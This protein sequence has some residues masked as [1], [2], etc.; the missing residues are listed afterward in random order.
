MTSMARVRCDPFRPTITARSRA[1]AAQT[2]GHEQENSIHTIRSALFALAAAAYILAITIGAAA[3]SSGPTTA[4][5]FTDIVV[6][7]SS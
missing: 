4:V 6:S 2:G 7:S 5:K 1:V 3:E